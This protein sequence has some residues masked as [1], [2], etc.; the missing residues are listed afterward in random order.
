MEK[1][2]PIK[3][4]KKFPEY[5]GR[6]REAIEKLI[7]EQDGYVPAVAHKEG[8]GDI[9]FVWGEVF[10]DH[11]GYGLSHIIRKRTNI[12][13]IDGITFAKK[14]PE[15]IDKGKISRGTKTR[16]HITYNNYDLI[17]KKTLDDKKENWVL[18]GF[19]KWD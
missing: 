1:S 4:G 3:L 7:Q 8:I 13:H 18:S 10:S 2:P 16:A 15:I 5:K 12:D 6:P 19:E 17:I 9:S 11:D 14:I